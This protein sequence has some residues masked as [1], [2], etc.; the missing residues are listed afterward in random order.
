MSIKSVEFGYTATACGNSA[1]A[2]NPAISASQ[3]GKFIV[4]TDTCKLGSGSAGNVLNGI[5]SQIVL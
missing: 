5:S 4:G 2:A 3:P 1:A